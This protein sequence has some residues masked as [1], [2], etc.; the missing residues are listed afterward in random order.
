MASPEY[1]QC[2]AYLEQ[3]AALVVAVFLSWFDARKEGEWLKEKD[4][5]GDTL[6]HLAL[7]YKAP[8]AVAMAMFKAWPDAAKV[9]NNAGYI[10]L[11][12]AA[13]HHASMLS[14]E[15]W[16]HHSQLQ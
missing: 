4:D 7:Y 9:K 5:D 13:K 16:S 15:Y 3:G 12:Y 10:P 8:Q 11:H 1:V 14:C 2:L 6:L